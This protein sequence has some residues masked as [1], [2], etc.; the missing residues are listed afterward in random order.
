MSNADA[1]PGFTTRQIAK[2]LRVGKDRV[3]SW[4]AAGQLRAIDT[5]SGSG[6]R[7]FIILPEDLAAFENRHQAGPAAK[8]P[9]RKKR[10]AAI[11]YFP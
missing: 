10:A 7:R 11:D 5:G 9:R 4:I 3:R 8:A 6:R 1:L 2:R